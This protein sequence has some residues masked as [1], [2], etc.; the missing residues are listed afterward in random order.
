MLASKRLEMEEMPTAEAAAEGEEV[1]V[2]LVPRSLVA[3]QGCCFL[4]PRS[5]GWI[6]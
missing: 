5:P 6:G 1:V 2:M 4:R 3:G